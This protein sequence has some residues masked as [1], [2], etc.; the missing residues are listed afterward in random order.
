MWPLHFNTNFSNGVCWH[1]KLFWV[2][3]GVAFIN[4]DLVSTDDD[5]AIFDSAWKWNDEYRGMRPIRLCGQ[6][7]IYTN[8]HLR[9]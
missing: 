4:V 2:L 7:R 9:N 5:R 1:A 6:P 3:I 8:R